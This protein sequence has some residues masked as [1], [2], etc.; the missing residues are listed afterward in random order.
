[1]T[2]SIDDTIRCLEVAASSAITDYA[3]V[4][5]RGYLKEHPA[6]VAYRLDL[7]ADVIEVVRASVARETANGR[8]EGCDP[9]SPADEHHQAVAEFAAHTCNCEWCRCGQGGPDPLALWDGNGDC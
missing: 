1:M 4:L 2:V 9:F 3:D 6:L 7:L 8:W 5:V